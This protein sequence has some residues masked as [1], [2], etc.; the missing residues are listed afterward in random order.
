MSCMDAEELS[1][2]FLLPNLVDLSKVG[3]LDLEPSPDELLTKGAFS[4][5]G[6][7]SDP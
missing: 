5:G 1:V 3:E 7:P 4:G 2:L 6:E